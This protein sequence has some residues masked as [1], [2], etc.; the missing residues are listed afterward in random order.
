[1]K[2]AAVLREAKKLAIPSKIEQ[3]K[4]NKTVKEVL[5]KV[6]KEARKQRVSAKLIIGGSVEKG[7][8]LPNL[9]DAD[10][11]ML[12]NYN[13]YKGKDI[14]K[15]LGRILRKC[16]RITKLHG[17]RDY[18]SANH[19]GLY[20]EFVPVLEIKKYNKAKN[21]TDCSPLHSKWIAKKASKK[22]KD[23]IRL[24]KLFFKANEV[25]GA[26]SYISGFSGHV[27]EILTIYCKSFPKLLQAAKKWKTKEVIDLEKYKTI[28]KINISKLDS[29]LIIIDPVE[30]YRNEAAALGTEKFSKL[31][32][33]AKKFLNKP[34]IEFFKE[35]EFD[36]KDLFK[37]KRKRKLI[38]LTIKPDKGKSD[39][40]GAKLLRKFQDLK[41]EF[42]K[43]DF[44]I[45]ESNWYWKP[46]KNAVS[47]F[48]FSKKSLP[49]IKYHPG[50]PV[51]M[52]KFAKHF[53]KKYKKTKTS[54][55]RVF[56]ILKRKYLKPEQLVKGKLKIL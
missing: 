3:A 48:Y 19:Q 24:A 35:K 9:R 14:S 17:S 2:V 54:K 40:V 55:G 23:E 33:A 11:F 53:R 42:R 49:K 28:K 7:T 43:N 4:V 44:E 37:K 16:F 25:Y 56:A 10:F 34:S 45:L 52:T 31:K 5:A 18:F 13:K 32:I 38:I 29:P 51:K 39:V 22:M 21:I 26:E 46:G 1:M 8:W 6:N 30:P 50:P 12:F 20:M 41:K 47:W 27:I 15:I 36:I